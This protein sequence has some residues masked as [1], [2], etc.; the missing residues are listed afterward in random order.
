MGLGD[1]ETGRRGGGETGRRGDR[2]TG[3]VGLGNVSRERQTSTIL[4]LVADMPLAS[5][6]TISEVST[7]VRSS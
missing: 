3:G 4:A 7:G 2:E 1:R 6:F 5:F